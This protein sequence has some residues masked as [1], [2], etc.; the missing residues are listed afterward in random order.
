MRTSDSIL[1]LASELKELYPIVGNPFR[2]EACGSKLYMADTPETLGWEAGSLYY[3]RLYLLHLPT[4]SVS[5]GGKPPSFAEAAYA[6]ECSDNSEGSDTEE[7][8][9]PEAAADA[10]SCS[11]TGEEAEDEGQNVRMEVWW[12]TQRV[13]TVLWG[14]RR[15]F[16]RLLQAL[17][18]I[19]QIPPHSQP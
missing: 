7:A 5:K 15:L 13:M 17:S 10:G 18:S 11:E 12:G 6:A 3:M 2:L 19:S 8:A 4:W 14:R 1:Y 9:P 16:R